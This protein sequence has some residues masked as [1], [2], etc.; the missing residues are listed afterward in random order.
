MLVGEEGADSKRV[1]QRQVLVCIAAN[2]V[3]GG[4][5]RCRGMVVCRSLVWLSL[6]ELSTLDVIVM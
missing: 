4:E 2:E 5:V 1:T 6:Y 3:D